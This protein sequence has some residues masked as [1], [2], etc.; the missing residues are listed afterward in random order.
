MGPATL[1]VPKTEEARRA[2]R[3]AWVLERIWSPKARALL[4]MEEPL[5]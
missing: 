5:P 2:G 1:T 4:L 3:A